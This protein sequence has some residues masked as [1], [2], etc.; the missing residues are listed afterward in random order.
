[1]ACDQTPSLPVTSR[2]GNQFNSITEEQIERQNA[3]DFYDALRNV[4]GVIY[5]KKT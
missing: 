5:Q 3:L 1:M 4:P 2:F